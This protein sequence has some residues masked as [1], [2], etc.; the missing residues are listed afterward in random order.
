MKA[1]THSCMYYSVMDL[2]HLNTTDD[3]KFNN[4]HNMKT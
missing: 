1:I 4:L 3:P 2:Y